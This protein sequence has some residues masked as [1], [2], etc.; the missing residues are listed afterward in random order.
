MDRL[1]RAIIDSEITYSEFE[2]SHAA[3]ARGSVTD[4]VAQARADAMRSAV[5]GAFD[6]AFK[7]YRA[8]ERRYREDLIAK[9]DEKTIQDRANAQLA[10]NRDNLAS[11]VA[12]QTRLL[13]EHASAVEDLNTK[14]SAQ[15]DELAGFLYSISHDLKSPIKTISSLLELFIED[16]SEAAGDLSL[17][18]DCLATTSRTLILLDRLFEFSKSMDDAIEHTDVDLNRIIDEIFSDIG[19]PEG[20][21]RPVFEKD[22]L[23]MITGSEFQIRLLFQ[24]LIS[25]AAKFCPAGQTPRVH[26]KNKGAR[27]ITHFAIAVSDNG[28][29][30]DPRHFKK[31][32]GLFQR[33]HAYHDYPGTGIGLALCDR[34]VRNHAGQIDLR[35]EVGHGST[36]IVTLPV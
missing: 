13:Q 30:I 4:R 27:G 10:R 20:D 6:K 35:S 33:L 19:R 29:G 8:L 11:E 34:I 12:I 24:N 23:P 1:A 21:C 15:R 16:Y 18:Q 31:I 25:N 14:L 17:I 22:T 9:R 2:D 28:I 7:A 36:F 5:L 32:F 3:L 26:V